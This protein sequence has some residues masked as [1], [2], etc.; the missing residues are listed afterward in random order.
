MA[1]GA[2]LYM[3]APDEPGWPLLAVLAVTPSILWLVLR[4]R[5]AGLLPLA[6]AFLACIAIGALSGKVRA[7]LVAAPILKEQ[8]GPVRIEGIVA[9]IDASE[10]SRR[11][12]VAVRAI[13]GLSPEQTPRFVRFSFK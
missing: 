7:T 13:E 4:R 9:E 12:R 6:V 10:R 2:A 5:G 11:I 1:A 8:I 3:T